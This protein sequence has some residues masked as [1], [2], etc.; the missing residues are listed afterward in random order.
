MEFSEKI[1]L[2]RKTKRYTQKNFAKLLGIGYSSLKNY[3]QGLRE[4]H[5][6]LPK[7]CQE[8]P[9]YTLWIMT[10]KIDLPNQTSPDNNSQANALAGVLDNKEN[11]DKKDVKKIV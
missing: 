2:I 3:E 7:L 1:K 6:I 8:F 11:D 4:S 10:G 9:Q 5:Q